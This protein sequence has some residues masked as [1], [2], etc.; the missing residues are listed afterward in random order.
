M[1]DTWTHHHRDIQ[2]KTTPTANASIAARNRQSRRRQIIAATFVT[3]PIFLAPPPQPPGGN[4]RQNAYSTR[5]V[6]C[7]MSRVA[8]YCPPLPPPAINA[9][10]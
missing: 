10:L 7:N 8:I 4:S 5:I 6:R 3:R 1:A 9:E 2:F